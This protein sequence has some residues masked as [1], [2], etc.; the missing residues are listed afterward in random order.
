MLN[1]TFSLYIFSFHEESLLPFPWVSSLTIYFT[2]KHN[3]KNANWK[4]TKQIATNNIVFVNTNQI[5]QIKATAHILDDETFYQT[6]IP[7]FSIMISGAIAIIKATNIAH[8][9]PSIINSYDVASET[10][11]I[12][13]SYLT[14]LVVLIGTYF[15]M[16]SSLPKYGKL[17]PQSH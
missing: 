6:H 13:K 7:L 4:F 11:S 8:F 16:T 5:K 10:N 3:N 14:W 12:F 2:Q 17:L 9:T 15:Q 1:T